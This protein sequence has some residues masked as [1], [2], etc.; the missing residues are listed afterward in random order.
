MNHNFEMLI[1]QTRDEK[2]KR[3]YQVMREQK[4]NEAMSERLALQEK[5]KKR[6]HSRIIYENWK[7]RNLR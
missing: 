3:F 1:N 2:L 7:A 6:K 4:E 5:A